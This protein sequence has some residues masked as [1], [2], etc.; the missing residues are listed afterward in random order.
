LSLEIDVALTVTVRVSLPASLPY[1]EAVRIAE[2]EAHDRVGQVRGVVAA[3][4]AMA[5]GAA[6]PKARRQG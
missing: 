4:L 2:D 5:P 6:M 3:A 1:G